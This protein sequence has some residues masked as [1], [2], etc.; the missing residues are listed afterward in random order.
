MH[1]SGVP[2]N[3]TSS[4]SIVPQNHIPSYSALEMYTLSTWP[5]G[6]PIQS[7]CKIFW[8]TWTTGLIFQNPTSDPMTAQVR[9]WWGALWVEKETNTRNVNVM[10]EWFSCSDWSMSSSSSSKPFHLFLPVHVYFPAAS[11]WSFCWWSAQSA[12][13]L[14]FILQYINEGELLY[15]GLF[16]EVQVFTTDS[17]TSLSYNSP[18]YILFLKVW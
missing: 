3:S 8:H 9:W 5:L 4:S 12:A 10:N 7:A 2:F 6:C 16:T 13:G 1:T 11:T 14:T 17:D 15:I 18:I